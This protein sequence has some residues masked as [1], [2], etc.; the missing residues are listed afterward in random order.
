[1]GVDQREE[2]FSRCSQ[3]LGIG[4]Y[5]LGIYV[6]TAAICRPVEHTFL[7]VPLLPYPRSP[8]GI[9]KSVCSCMPPTD[10]DRRWKSLYI[11]ES[12]SVM[13]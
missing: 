11:E 13:P 6:P 7:G 10:T 12:E 1:M 5:G 4:T 2:R 8:V 3:D 9:F